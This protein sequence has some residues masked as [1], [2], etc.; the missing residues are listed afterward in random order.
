MIK[1]LQTQ[2]R[3]RKKTIAQKRAECKAQ[4]LIYDH[5]I[6]KCRQSKR[7]SRSKKKTIAQKRAE[8][9][10]QGL[11]YDH[12]IGKCRQSKRK[13]RSKKKT[14]AQKRA[15]CKAQGLIY[16]HKIGKCR[17]RKSR[18]K[19]KTIAQKRAECK[20]QGL[21]YDHKIGKCRQSK[22]KSK[23]GKNVQKFDGQVNIEKDC[24]IKTDMLMFDPLID[25]KNIMKKI[26]KNWNGSCFDVS[27][28]VDYLISNDGINKDPM[29]RHR[30]DKLWRDKTELK[31]L[32]QFI[33]TAPGIDAGKKKRIKSILSEANI[34]PNISVIRNH[35]SLLEDIFKAGCIAISDNPSSFQHGIFEDSAIILGTL[36]KKLDSLSKKDRNVFLNLK[37]NNKHTLTHILKNA[38]TRC[39]HG[40]GWELCS[41]YF[42]TLTNINKFF[43]NNKIKLLP[44]IQQRKNGIKLWAVKYATKNTE[45]ERLQTG[46]WKKEINMLD[47][48]IINL[49]FQQFNVCQEI[50][51]M[52]WDE[53]VHSDGGTSR[54][55][56]YNLKNKQWVGTPYN[57]TAKQTMKTL[58][59]ADIVKLHPYPQKENIYLELK[60][61][62]IIK[63]EKKFIKIFKKKGI[64]L[65][66]AKMLA[67]NK[68]TVQMI[69]HNTFTWRQITFMLDPGVLDD[70]YHHQ[71]DAM[72]IIKACG[73]NLLG[74]KIKKK[75]ILILQSSFDNNN[76][77][78][79]KGDK[80]IFWLFNQFQKYTVK[81]HYINSVSEIMNI[82][83]KSS[84]IAHLV[85]MAHGTPTSIQLSQNHSFTIN[86]IPPFAKAL[87]KKLLPH[88]S[89]FLHS[90]SVGKGGPGK[91]NFAQTLANQFS[92]KKDIIVFAADKK[93][94]RDT[95]SITSASTNGTLKIIYQFDTHVNN[96]MYKFKKNPIP[97]N[98]NRFKNIIKCVKNIS[99]SLDLDK[100]WAFIQWLEEQEEEERYKEMMGRK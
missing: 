68:I 31:N 91:K 72:M 55:N 88:S 25:Q 59:H 57:S 76:A 70:P 14:I 74:E 32:M 22:R 7:K 82:I 48:K 75:T 42:Q 65:K 20:T 51:V 6:G 10:A 77:F 63:E 17:Q 89:I 92:K 79:K 66:Y 30:T 95:V 81:H 35:L 90:C 96:T 13:S 27:Q 87:N 41:L 50:T 11:I 58:S 49:L 3:S 69:K 36:G 62:S 28:L 19:K 23:P 38:H 99:N 12:K 40:V 9:K 56:R 80:G 52:Q 43:P 44:G 18:S 21:I 78:E 61:L 73:G 98:K 54:V 2:S 5:K 53:N 8:C 47:K 85:I 34:P 94:G 1:S 16:D 37:L 26:Y 100:G 93:I 67:R 15:E 86:D 33:N 4:G 71:D 39:I 60:P 84:K 29:I 46:K 24:K 64:P 83:R 97:E 45:L